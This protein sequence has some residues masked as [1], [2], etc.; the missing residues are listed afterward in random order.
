MAEL[1]C[2]LHVKLEVTWR[3]HPSTGT[4]VLVVD[5][6]CPVACTAVLAAEVNCPIA[7]T[8]VPVAGGTGVL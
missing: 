5:V 6:L 3:N 7:G 1:S 8:A 2:G 4:A